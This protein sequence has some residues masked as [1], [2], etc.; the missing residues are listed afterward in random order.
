[1]SVKIELEKKE[2]KIKLEKRRTR[3]RLKRNKKIGKFL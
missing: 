1:M 2:F 3:K